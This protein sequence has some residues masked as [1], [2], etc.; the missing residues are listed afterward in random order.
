MALTPLIYFVRITVWGGTALV[1]VGW[2]SEHQVGGTRAL[3]GGRY[4]WRV[5]WEEEGDVPDRRNGGWHTDSNFQ[6]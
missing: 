2:G 5:N 6:S 3:S 4:W 1:S